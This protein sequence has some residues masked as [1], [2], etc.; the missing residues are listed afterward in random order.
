[1]SRLLLVQTSSGYWDY[2]L[3]RGLPLPVLHASAMAARTHDV[4]ILDLR[5]SPAPG[6]ILAKT[7]KEKNPDVV[8][9]TVMIGPQIHEAITL[10]RLVKRTN[11]QTRVAWGGVFPSMNPELVFSEPAVDLVVS[12]EGEQALLELADALDETSQPKRIP[13]ILSRGDDV[14]E[15]G[16]DRPFLD[17]D[18]L[19]ML[20][21]ERLGDRNIK[22]FREGS[23]VSLET[24][25]GCPGECSF[26]Y[27]KT[28]CKR[29]WRARSAA[30]VDAD[31]EHLLRFFDA[32]KLF[33]MDDNFFVNQTRA[34]E[35]AEIFA[36]RNIRWGTH[37]LTPDVAGRLD[38]SYLRALADTGCDEMKIGVENVSPAIQSTMKKRFDVDR[39][40]DFNRRAGQFG[41]RIQYSFI[42]GFPGETIQ[43]IETNINFIL[44]LL[45]ENPLA[46]L[47]MIN[48]LF[49][50]PETEVYRDHTDEQWKASW[51]LERYGTFE[52]NDS[53]GPWVDAK[54][55]ELLKKINLASMFLSIKSATSSRRVTG[56]TETVRKSYRPIAEYRLRKL[57]FR[58]A[59]ELRAGNALL[60]LVA[61]LVR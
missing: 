23:A 36:R 10:S 48:T 31:I 55:F 1:M 40:R 14:S 33:V 13:G 9:F 45:R 50:Y 18:A 28:F 54:R 41:F 58:V 5:S 59:P 51:P 49:P 19:P 25:R 39:F 37:G 2:L 3:G 53:G 21:Y 8:G 38:N 27:S 16:T 11:P 29:R 24:A 61:R 7:V 60:R 32:R 26:C 42:L 56:L 43:D 17:L 6:R 46:D 22:G 15:S 4:S 30:R 47:F 20:P 12:G 44:T 57:A 52:I 35:I 34:M